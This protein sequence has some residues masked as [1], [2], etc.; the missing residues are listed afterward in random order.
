LVDSIHADSDL[1]FQFLSTSATAPAA[2]VLDD[3]TV[4]LIYRLPGLS[5]VVGIAV[6]QS[7]TGIC[8][9]ATRYW[10]AVLAHNMVSPPTL[11]FFL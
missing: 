3:S 4:D 6:M 8:N 1:I 5:I 9:F 11:T 7:A 10:W 2:G